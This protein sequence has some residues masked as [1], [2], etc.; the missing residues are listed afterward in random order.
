[1]GDVVGGA[2]EDL[3]AGGKHGVVVEGH[4][5]VVGRAARVF[6][7]AA[8]RAL[9]RAR[10]D[11]RQPIAAAL[12]D[13]GFVFHQRLVAGGLHQHAQ[14]QHAVGIHREIRHIEQCLAAVW[15]AVGLRGGRC[16]AHAVLRV[17]H[18]D[19]ARGDGNQAGG[20]AGVGGSRFDVEFTVRYD[21]HGLIRVGEDAA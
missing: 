15:D 3:L 6:D 7:R 2:V 10:L 5:H 13:D 21:R 19:R 20:V 12:L 17:P 4:G 1:M 18:R 16:G 8:V 9:A 14:L 11:E